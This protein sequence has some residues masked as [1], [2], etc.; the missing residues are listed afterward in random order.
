MRRIKGYFVLVDSPFYEPVPIS[1]DLTFPNG[2]EVLTT[3]A[4]LSYN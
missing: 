3:G 2:G 4:I 1:L